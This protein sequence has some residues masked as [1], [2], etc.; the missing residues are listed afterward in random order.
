MSKHEIA[1]EG[2]LKNLGAAAGRGFNKLRKKTRE[3]L[4]GPAGD[5]THTEIQP[6]TP[7]EDSVPTDPEEVKKRNSRIKLPSQLTKGVGVS[8]FKEFFFRSDK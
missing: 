1:K 6:E 8:N 5:P 3:H 4:S 7:D 2:I